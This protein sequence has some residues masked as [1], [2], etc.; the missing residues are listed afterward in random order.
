VPCRSSTDPVVSNRQRIVLGRFLRRNGWSV[1][2]VCA[3]LYLFP[4]FPAIQS[5]NELPRI[6]LVQAMVD[7]HTFAIDRGVKTWGATFDVSTANGHS[8]SNKAPGSS[9]LAVPFYAAMEFVVGVPSLAATMWLCRMV[10]G[11]IP[12]LVLLWLLW[13]FLARFAP[14]PAVR[15]LVVVGYAF[16]SMALTYSILYYSHQLSAVC[17]ASAWILA[18]DVAE[19]RRGLRAMVGIG[20]LA[21]GAILTD[22]QAGFA[23]LPV[24]IDVAVRMRAWKHRQWVGGLALAAGGA[25]L[26]VALLLYYH[27]VCFGSPLRTGY[28]LSTAAHGHGEG[29]LGL[30]SPSWHH[31]IAA[32]IAP[33][34]VFTLAP[35]LL[36]AIPGAVTLGRRDRATAITCAAVGCVMLWF[37]S[38]LRFPG[39]WE[40]GPRYVVVML[41]FFLPLVAA[42]LQAWRDRALVLGAAAGMIV[43]GVAVYAVS[44]AT[45]PYWIDYVANPLYELAFRM[46]G[47]GL[48]APDIVGI[49]GVAGVVPFAALVAGVMAWAV[50]RACRWR[51]LAICSAVGVAILLAYSLFPATGARSE[52]AYAYVR[53]MMDKL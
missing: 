40:V 36:L 19:G 22:Y 2:I 44:A 27:A 43:V 26:P 21:G 37:I 33:V 30:S 53:S 5:A 23:A 34:G 15:R 41:P 48:F 7:D 50:V 8:Y 9:M 6:Y 42:Q 20:A 45:F 12:T 31:F 29:L 46:V 4:Y 1:A 18:I 13:G 38:S 51:G 52:H 32:T 10:T 11:V 35:W 24:A 49:P 17:L 3:Y 16:G 47:D 14:D 39:G 25:A 28:D